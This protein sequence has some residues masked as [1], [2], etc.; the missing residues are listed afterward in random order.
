M[1]IK[2]PLISVIVPVYK[3]ERYLEQCIESILH[4]TYRQLEII[5]VDDGSP[6]R[7]GDICDCYAEQDSRIRVIHQ[8]NGGL[9]CARNAGLA[10]ATGDY[11][12]YVDSD[13]Y[14]LP[15]MYE[16]LLQGFEEHENVGII[17]CSYNCLEDGRVY[18]TPDYS[19]MKKPLMF[20]G[21]I[22]CPALCL[23]LHR[24]WTLLK[25]KLK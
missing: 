15:T 10:I 19:P 11:I 3:V 8:A 16:E 2:Q 9:S 12:G 23:L 18:P 13:D 14:L 25:N 17:A 20:I 24:Y 1:H 22:Y 5:L 7:C 21:M 4:Q 6:D